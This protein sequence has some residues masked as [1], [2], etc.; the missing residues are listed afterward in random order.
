VLFRSGVGGLGL[1][2][3][4]S[5]MDGRRARFSE[6]GSFLSLAAPGTTVFGALAASARAS[7]FARVELPGGGPGRYGL[8]SGTSYAAPQ[9]AGAAALVWG[10]NPR[11][12]AQQV[13]AVLEQTA[14][15]RGAWSPELGYGVIDVSAA[16]DLA[17]R[18][19][20]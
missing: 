9:V 17:L 20:S 8:A 4:A 3:A 6:Y 5:G 12:T 13:A 11:L 7:L 14:S 19:A 16:V 1:A 15:G 2:V 18:L 10:A